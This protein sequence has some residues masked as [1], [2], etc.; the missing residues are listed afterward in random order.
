MSR[1]R[2]EPRRKNYGLEIII[3]AAVLL[4]IVSGIQYLFT[5]RG[6]E[7]EARQLAKIRL[8]N[9]NLVVEGAM[10]TV[11][12]A[13]GNLAGFVSK[14]ASSPESII[15]M[16]SALLETN[17]TI[18]ECAVLFVPDYYGKGKVFHPASYRLA[19]GTIETVDHADNGFD[20]YQRDW[21]RDAISS[22]GKVWTDPYI[23][24][25]D[26][27]LICTFSQPI[28][29]SGGNIIAVIYGDI[30]MNWLQ[31]LV[32]EGASSYPG[33][34][35]VILGKTG[36]P[37]IDTRGGKVPEAIEDLG[38]HMVAHE[39]GEKKITYSDTVSYAYYSP[40]GQNGWS[41]AIVCPEKEM[42]K[43]FY[44]IS[45]ILALLMLFGLLLLGFI[46]W[47]AT[48]NY[49][50][51][52]ILDSEKHRMENELNIA[53]GIQMGM[54][55]KIV[56]SHRKR[57][58]IDIFAS[59]TA[60]REVGGDL[61]DFFIGKDDVWFCIG[62]VSGKGVPASLVMAVTRS[63]FRTVV[64]HESTPEGVMATMNDS[65]SEMNEN[66]MF[67]TM[68]IGRLGLFSGKLDYCNAGHTA[69]VV[70]RSEG[71]SF[72]LMKPN[73]ALGLMSGYQYTGESTVLKPGE[74][75]FL[76]TDGITEATNPNNELFGEARMMETLNY[77]LNPEEL[78]SSVEKAVENFTEGAQ[79]SDDL[80]M[81][82]IRFKGSSDKRIT[83]KHELAEIEKIPSLIDGLGLDEI[84]S[85]Q[86]NLAI[87]EAATNI[88]SYSSGKG[89]IEISANKQNDQVVITLKDDGKPFDPT[90]TVEPDLSVEPKERPI[91]GLGI[92][93]VRKLMD[94]IS[95]ERKDGFNILTL[96]KNL[97]HK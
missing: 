88:I 68:F 61:Y 46:L 33:A 53:H 32:E 37:V 10:N 16:T 54:V 17:R 24:N 71:N 62:D 39:I 42:F 66:N 82:A 95:Y 79:Q 31:A 48:R 3:A 65:M 28:R 44:K 72:I 96:T 85:D 77:K 15:E 5:K 20:Y 30:S 76:Y 9:T 1:S 64:K 19:D 49:L 92:F 93:L 60:A 23:S 56:P 36:K 78:L 29:D 18:S 59:L 55:P 25:T 8:E 84:T 58:D 97:I 81:L 69:P 51:L 83:L 57:D 50:K 2:Q 47:R 75:L 80:T 91:G 21:Y 43:E 34:F 35:S 26:K 6:I 7:N 52:K 63:L 38:K 73:L 45:N 22:G 94:G 87:E 40:I 27:N 86:L 70:L 11:E 89:D 14:Y 74:T 13:I 4:Q 41:M 12:V 67:V 90:S